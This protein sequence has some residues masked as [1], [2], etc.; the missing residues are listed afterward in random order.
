MNKLRKVIIVIITLIF[1][2]VAIETAFRIMYSI[3]YKNPKYLTVGLR[4]GSVFKFNV[5]FY[6]GYI[7]LNK[8]WQK[9]GEVCHGF[10]T[11]SFSIEK[12]KDE[13]RIVA[14]GGSSTYAVSQNYKGSWPYLLEQELN[15]RCGENHQYYKV[16]NAGVPMQ[17][18]YGVYHLLKAEVLD[19]HPDLIL[20]Y[21]LYNH[22]YFDTPAIYRGS[23]KGDYYFRI[24]QGMFY[25]KSLV[26]TYLV[27]FIGLR[28]G[29]TLRNKIDTYRHLLANIVKTC[30]DNG[31][32]II[33]I[34]QLIN[35]E[36]F[37]RSKTN[38]CIR[39][40]E[41]YAPDQYRSFLNI[42]DE[43]CVE[44]DCDSI[45]FSAFSPVCKDKLNN[46]LND[47]AVHLTNSGNKLL[48][49]IIAEKLIEM[50]QQEF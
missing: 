18:T 4:D 10:R 1:S 48:A 28:S 42:I 3:K 8:Y 23:G 44:Y 41:N 36:Q 30:K 16:I 24:I 35:P 2:L 43:V 22:I 33:V 7:K 37:L 32:D 39:D 13:Y 26:A 9:G 38:S 49:N 46:L 20:L 14:L 17:T 6:N 5:D 50:R 25:N 27:N 45:D 12:P 19:W 34:K 40:G 11:S 29:F 21:S 47:D 15:E 31:I